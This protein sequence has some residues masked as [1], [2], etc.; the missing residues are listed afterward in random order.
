VSD[1]P[2]AHAPA[3]LT[4][5]GALLLVRTQIGSEADVL[6]YLGEIIDNIKAEK[7]PRIRVS[8][9][10]SL[11]ADSAVKSEFASKSAASLGSEVFALGSKDK[12]NEWVALKT[13]NMIQQVLF[14]DVSACGG[15]HVLSCATCL[16]SAVL[17][18]DT[19][20]PLSLPARAR[21]RP[22][23]TSL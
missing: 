8:L 4:A 12:I 17:T 10:V 22:V 19:P 13:R 15:P 20:A 21:S 6:G 16:L 9:A 18:A 23:P 2:C 11:W 14:A 7:D 3:W 5:S 1:T